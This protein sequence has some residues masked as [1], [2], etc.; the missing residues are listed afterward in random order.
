MIFI[1]IENQMKHKKF[2][3]E[4]DFKN[5]SDIFYFYFDLIIF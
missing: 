5:I 2:I 4:N 3:T 1:K